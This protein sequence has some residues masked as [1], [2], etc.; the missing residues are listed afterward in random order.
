MAKTNEKV[1]AKRRPALRTAL[2]RQSREAALNAVQTFNNPLTT[3]KTE[4][5]IVLMVIA[6]TYLLHAYYRQ[7]GVEY[8]YHT[9]GPR[10]RKFDRTRSGDYKYWD[11]E[12]CLR[13]RDCPLDVPTK[14]N[15]RFLNGLRNEIQ[16]HRSAGV[17]DRFTGRYLACCL[18]YEKYV[19][20]LFGSKYSLGSVAAFTLQ[21]RD[22]ESAPTHR[23]A[24]QPL[25][26]N[27]SKYVVDFDG[28]LSDETLASPSFRRRFL[29]VPVVTNKEAQA[30]EVI[31]F[32]PLESDLGKRI[33]SAYRQIVLKEVERPKHLPGE[34]VRLMR[35]EGFHGFSMHHHTLLWKHLDA[36]NPGKGLGA[37]V[38][39][40]W[41]WYDRWLQV[42]RDHCNQHRGKY[43]P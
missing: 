16:H 32:V 12:R 2:L 30:D 28:E 42:V 38:A 1:N 10:R 13:D 14:E 43:C 21:F 41:Y 18:N 7:K 22:L 23:D 33:S 31:Q 35:S 24:V 6:W 15:L 29:F 17:D 26:A 36:R 4:T 25:P 40:T 37:C 9:K 19:S 39:G 3:F 27:V 20:S 34:I 11:L 5:F 8:R